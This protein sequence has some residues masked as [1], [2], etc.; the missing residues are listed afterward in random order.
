MPEV[1]IGA[2]NISST[3]IPNWKRSTAAL[4]LFGI[5]FGYVEA[6]VVTYLNAVYEPLR[7]RVHT[8]RSSNN[9]FPI[10]P[11]DELKAADPQYLRLLKVELAREFATLGMLAAAAFLVGSSG[12]QWLA[13]FLIAFGSWD[14][15]FYAF[16][17]LLLHWPD[18]WLTWDL[19]FLIPVPWAAPVL[20]PVLVS[21][22]MIGG[23]LMYFARESMR[24][25]VTLAW[26]HWVGLIASGLILVGA[27]TSDFRNISA[28]GMPGSFPWPVFAVAEAL[29][30]GTFLH[31]VLS[32]DRGD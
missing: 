9:V 10:I 7:Q 19:L 20:A 17:K 15:S 11:V 21:V 16:L 3:R 31:A 23:G 26:P 29:G 22:T 13:A 24:R 28:G 14:L 1:L 5:S 6:S 32:S 27:C 4:L 2:R 25:P 8:G 12:A 30:V 18:S